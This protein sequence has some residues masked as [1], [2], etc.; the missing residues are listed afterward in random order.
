MSLIQIVRR[1]SALIVLGAF[2]GSAYPAGF[3]AVAPVTLP[4]AD[5][6]VDGPYF[7]KALVA[8]VTPT[9]GNALQQQAQQRIEA[10]LGVNSVLANG[11]AITKVQASSS[12]LGYIANHFNEIDAA[13][14]GRV[15]MDDV[16]RYLQ[17]KQMKQMK[18]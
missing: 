16:R 17:A 2:A 12:G 8:A 3:Q 4:H 6:G 1:V 7:P 13:H 18:Q 14:S 15:S 9:T 11:A 5:R 10:Q